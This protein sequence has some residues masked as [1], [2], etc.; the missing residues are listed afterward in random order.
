MSTKPISS[1]L[2]LPYKYGSVM[3]RSRE[4]PSALGS[5]SWA[6]AVFWACRWV[7]DMQLVLAE[8]GVG[9]RRR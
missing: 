7:A 1:H 4:P 2:L 3:E 5:S 6:W 9:G 8:Q